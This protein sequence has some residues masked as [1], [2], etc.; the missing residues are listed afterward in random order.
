MSGKYLWNVQ[1]AFTALGTLLPHYYHFAILYH[2]KLRIIIIIC[3]AAESKYQKKKIKKQVI[4]KIQSILAY[5]RG[6]QESLCPLKNKINN[7]ISNTGQ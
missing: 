3:L 6:S 7:N 5:C 1:T 4:N 2:G